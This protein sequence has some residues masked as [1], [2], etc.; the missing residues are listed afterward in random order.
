MNKQNN[1]SALTGILLMGAILIIFNMFVFNNSEETPNSEKSDITE[2]ITNSEVTTDNK[3]NLPKKNGTE[4]IIDSTKIVT[5]EFYT[6][7][8][9]KIKIDQ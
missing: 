8:N 4:D 3:D 2:E 5:E 6:L 7:K 9:D 1:K